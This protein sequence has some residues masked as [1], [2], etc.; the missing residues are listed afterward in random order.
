MLSRVGS[1]GQ[2]RWPRSPVQHGR[3]PPFF[4]WLAGWGPVIPAG[5]WS[6]SREVRLP[7]TFHCNTVLPL[8]RSKT[9]RFDRRMRICGGKLNGDTLNRAIPRRQGGPRRPFDK[10][11]R[12]EEATPHAFPR[13]SHFA[14]YYHHSWN[15][16]LARDRNV[17]ATRPTRRVFCG[18]LCRASTPKQRARC[19]TPRKP[20]KPNRRPP[21]SR[22]AR[23]RRW[24]T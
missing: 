8:A 12:L 11:R 16:G 7:R 9:R 21:H 20:R 19:T 15:G 14:D 17:I 1:S 10:A 5:S 23:P 13:R 24:N 18:R 4:V 6:A 3:R 22:T 2:A